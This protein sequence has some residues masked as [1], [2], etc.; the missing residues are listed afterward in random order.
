MTRSLIKMN[1]VEG[2]K[3]PKL[4]LLLHPSASAT[5]TYMYSVR[6]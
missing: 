3:P 5:Y 6:I 2:A 1:P 4:P